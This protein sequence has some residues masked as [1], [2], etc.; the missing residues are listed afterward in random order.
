MPIY[1]REEAKSGGFAQVREALLS[2]E[3][4]VVKVE[5]GQWGGKLVDDDGKPVPPREYFEVE[6]T[7]NVPLEVTEELSMDISERFSFRVNMS[8]YEGSFWVDAFLASAEKAK[9]LL[10][11]GIKGKRVTFRKVTLEGSEPKYNVTNFVI[12]KVA[13]GTKVAPK[14]T[15]KAVIAPAPVASKETVEEDEIA[16][17]LNLAV[18]KTEAQFRSA[19]SLHPKLIGSQLL[20]LIKAGLFT[21]SQVNEGTLTL[22]NDDKYAK[23]E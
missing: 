12:D 21:A 4:D 13:G 14:V 5:T 6:T 23:P 11:D 19:A 9:V 22:G 18:G 16:L 8:E 15:P 17:A 3:G 1:K 10:P 7:N 20:P 2:Y